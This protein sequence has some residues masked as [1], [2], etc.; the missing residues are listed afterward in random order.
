MR[1]GPV[2]AL[3]VESPLEPEL[4]DQLEDYCQAEGMTKTTVATQ[5]LR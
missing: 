5:A 4:E 3:I 1:Q 2:G